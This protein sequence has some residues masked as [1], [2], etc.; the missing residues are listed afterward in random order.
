VTAGACSA[1]ADGIQVLAGHTAQRFIVEG[2][3]KILIADR[4]GAPVRIPFDAVLV[5]VGRAA[6]TQGYGLE[7][8][9]IGTTPQRTV[10]T[11]AA[12]QTIY[13]NIY[14][15]GDVAG[16]YQFTHTASHQA[17]YAAVNALFG[18]FRRFD[19]DYRVIPWATL[20]IRRSRAGL[21]EQE[22]GEERPTRP[23]SLG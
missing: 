16:P 19:A 4:E 13:P 2:G 8:L 3:E 7:E 10:S 20:L 22:A 14:A 1:W 5:A 23:L 18:S 12:L 9:G 6:N 17:W 11:D 15:C 21:S